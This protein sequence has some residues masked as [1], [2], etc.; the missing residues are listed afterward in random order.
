MKNILII[1][2]IF[3]KFDT[4]IVIFVSMFGQFLNL[5]ND[6]MGMKLRYSMIYIK[7]F[8]EKYFSRRKPAIM[9]DI[10][11]EM[12]YTKGITQ[13]KGEPSSF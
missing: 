8:T 11:L 6:F 12:L 9:I 1:M 2:E 7:K 13:F 3:F 5:N 10:R 4:C